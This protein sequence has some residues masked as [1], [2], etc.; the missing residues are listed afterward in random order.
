LLRGRGRGI[1]Q[2]RIPELRPNITGLSVLQDIDNQ[3]YLTV[4]SVTGLARSAVRHWQTD[5][6]WGR[7]G[8]L[9][10]RAQLQLRRYS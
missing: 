1:N 6:P 10:L 3:P 9:A 4:I 5:Q 2:S 7:Y 8:G